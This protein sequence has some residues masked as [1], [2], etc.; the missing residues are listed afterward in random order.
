MMEPDG[1]AQVAVF[2]DFENLVLGAVKE[3]PDLANSAPYEALTRL[4]RS[5]GNA[6][7]RRAYADWANPLFGSHQDD[8]AMNGVDLIQVA[9]VGIQNKNAA[10]IRM[11][12]DAMETLIVHPEISVFILVSGDGDYS[13]LVQRLREFGKWVV[14]VGT[15]ANA[16]RKLVSVSSEYK[17]WG[18]LVAE[19][20]PE[21]RPAAE[22]DIADAGRLLVRALEESGVETMTAG[23]LKSKM[24]ALDPAFDEHN[25]GARSF[26]AFLAMLPKQVEIVEAG[27]PDITV[28]LIEE[29]RKTTRTRTRKSL[30]G[31]ADRLPERLRVAEHAEHVVGDVGPGDEHAAADVLPVGRSVPASDGLVGQPR[32][33]HD[34]P[35]QVAATQYVFHPGQVGV[36]RAQRP[37][38]DGVGQVPDDE[39]VARVVPGRVRA[40]RRGNGADRRGAHHDDAPGAGGLHGLGDGP[41]APGGDARLGLGPGAERG[42]HRVGAGDRGLER[43]RVSGGQVGGRGPGPGG[44]QTLRVSCHGRYV[45][46]SGYGL[47]EQLPADAAGR[48]EDRQ[49]HRVPPLSRVL[50][51]Q[52]FY[53]QDD[54]GDQNVT[55]RTSRLGRSGQSSGEPTSAGRVSSRRPGLVPRCYCAPGTLP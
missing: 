43:G 38:D 49:L 11:A 41:G 14:G 5:Y 20:E 36:V 1:S 45:M 3:L 34:G 4:S 18:T 9:R 6:S 7:V 55:G 22:F 30:V 16:S 27:G 10:D 48:R 12:V 52:R 13:P 28:K 24:L 8:L 15:E 39:A 33:P 40:G 37:L 44:G 31:D 25:Y 50:G 2:V 17:Y 54:R 53:H 23:G 32:R 19:V 21:A 35:V 26:R 46:A 47:L 42:Q 51:P 29:P